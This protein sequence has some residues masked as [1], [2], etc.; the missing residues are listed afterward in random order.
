M[1][2]LVGLDAQRGPL[3]AQARAMGAPVLVS[4]NSLAQR[5]PCPAGVPR[6]VQFR[7]SG[8]A[9]LDGLDAH[10]DSAG[11][12]A[13]VRYR[14]FDWAVAQYVALGAAYPWRWFASMDA[15]VEPEVAPDRRTV[16]ERLAWTASLNR[17]CL[18]EAQAQGCADRLMPVIQG[19]RAED[20]ARCLDLMPGAADRAI[21]GVGSMC[22]RATG[23]V[24]GVLASVDAIDRALGDAPALLHLFG[25][26]SD[27]AEALRGHPRVASA[28]SQAYG[29][30]ARSQAHAVNRA[31]AGQADLLQNRQRVAK[32]RSYV[33]GFMGAWYGKQTARLARA[34]AAPGATGMLGLVQAPKPT[35]ALEARHQAA[36]EAMLELLAAGEIEWTDMGEAAVGRHGRVGATL[37]RARPDDFR[38]DCAARGAGSAPR[39]PAPRPSSPAHGAGRR[40]VPRCYVVPNGGDGTAAAPTNRLA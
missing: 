17:Q 34:G 3:L 7:T 22:R 2:M 26:K 19:A 15:C 37:L 32:T 25:V 1:R 27:A 4:A 13:M 18:L 30:R 33:A 9:V 28:D 40:S 31:G 6:F 24:D 12:V 8:L 10:L 35:S 29:V 14:G 36:R 5:R 16:L 21:L 11:F 23:G 20:Y 39:W 38:V